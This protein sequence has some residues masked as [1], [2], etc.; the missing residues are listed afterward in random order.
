MNTLQT[1]SRR[2]QRGVAVVEMVAITPVMLLLLLGIGELGKAILEYNTLNKS[3]RDAARFVA[4]EALLGT[5]GAVQLTADIESAARN[6]VVYGNV[7]GTGSPRLPELSTEQIS[8][9]NAGAGLVLV[10]ADYPYIPIMGPTLE[11]FGFGD[12][13][14]LDFNL[15]ASVTMRAL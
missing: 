12:D 14:G 4:G 2:R 3:V 10:R 9:S 8:V 6:L 5:T 15:T 13:I 11:T 7:N 1:Y